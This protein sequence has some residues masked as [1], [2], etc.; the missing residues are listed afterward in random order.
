MKA[1]TE[2]QD[3]RIRGSDL[4]WFKSDISNETKIAILDW[5]DSLPAEQ[6]MYVD[7]LRMDSKD[8]ALFFHDGD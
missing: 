3:R 5:Y 8:E 4:F 1:L 7:L 2:E 6:Q